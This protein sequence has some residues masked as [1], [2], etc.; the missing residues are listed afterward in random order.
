MAKSVKLI[1]LVLGFAAVLAFQHYRSKA[2]L[3]E[4]NVAAVTLGQLDD[5]ILALSLIHI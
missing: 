2:Q 4:V 5:S 1:L 3:L